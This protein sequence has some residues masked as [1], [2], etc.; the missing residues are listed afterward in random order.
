MYTLHGTG[1]GNR[2]GSNGLLYTVCTV[3][4]APD[5]FQMGFG[6]I[7]PYLILVPGTSVYVQ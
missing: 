5:N 4:I 6:P 3:H 1:T 2:N 7:F